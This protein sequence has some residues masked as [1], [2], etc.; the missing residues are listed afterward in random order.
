MKTVQ[1]LGA[2]REAQIS[3]SLSYLN[4]FSISSQSAT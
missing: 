2:F 3:W 4:I 1:K